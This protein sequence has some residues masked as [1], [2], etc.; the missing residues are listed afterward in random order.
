MARETLLKT[1]RLATAAFGPISPVV[2]AWRQWRGKEDGARLTERIGHPTRAR[3]AGQLVW[4]HGA[5]VGE[6]LALLPLVERLCAR[7]VPTLMTT[8]TVTSARVLASRMPGGC[9]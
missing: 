1:Y 8:G 7:G 4:L 6:G 9:I 5:S 3:E 2:L